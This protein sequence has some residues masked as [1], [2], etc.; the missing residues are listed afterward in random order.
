MIS[1]ALSVLDEPFRACCCALDDDDG[2]EGV[3][4]TGVGMGEYEGDVVEE[5][6]LLIVDEESIA[7][8]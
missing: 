8:C 7:C 5:L 1:G 4:V 6:G 3:V 2:D